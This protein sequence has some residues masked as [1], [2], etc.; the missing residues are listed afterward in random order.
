[1]PDTEELEIIWIP[2][3]EAKN[4]LTV[5]NAQGVNELVDLP[6]STVDRICKKKYGHTNWARMG[7]LYPEDLAR[8]PHEI[9]Y[10]EGIVYFKN[11][12]MV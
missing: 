7:A 9:D 2:E 10:L 11:L 1:M 8:N 12:R 6:A 3:E 5:E 4:S